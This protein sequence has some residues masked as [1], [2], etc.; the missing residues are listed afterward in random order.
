MKAVFDW[1]KRHCRGGHRSV[2]NQWLKT[3][4]KKRFVPSSKHRG[5][6]LSCWQPGRRW[7]RKLSGSRSENH[8]I[9]FIMPLATYLFLDSVLVVYLKMI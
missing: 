7:R 4:E 2:F 9:L 8:E 5:G 3:D 6:D 1:I